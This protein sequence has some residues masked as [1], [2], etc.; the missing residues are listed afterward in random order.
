MQTL[1]QEQVTPMGGVIC[2]TVDLSCGQIKY[3]LEM[4][5]EIIHVAKG[6]ANFFWWPKI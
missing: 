5:S 3:S 2:T 4:C 6:D 1:A